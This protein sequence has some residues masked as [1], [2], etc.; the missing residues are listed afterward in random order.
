MVYELM[1]YTMACKPIR[2]QELQYTMTIYFCN[3]CYQIVETMANLA[4]G[5]YNYEGNL[6]S[7]KWLLVNRLLERSVVP[8]TFEV[9]SCSKNCVLHVYRWIF[10]S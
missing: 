10:G 7:K 8:E 6:H 1:K 2:I 9:A 5:A 4:G 3:I